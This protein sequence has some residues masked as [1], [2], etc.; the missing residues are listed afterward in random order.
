MSFSLHVLCTLEGD[1]AVES[2]GDTNSEFQD[3]LMA[4]LPE[5]HRNFARFSTQARA[6]PYLISILPMLSGRRKVHKCL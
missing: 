2:A 6:T 4:H 1:A 5:S 3:R